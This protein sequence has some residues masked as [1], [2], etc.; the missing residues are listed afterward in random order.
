MRI[1]VLLSFGALGVLALVALGSGLVHWAATNGFG[2]GSARRLSTTDCRARKLI[3]TDHCVGFDDSWIECK[4]YF[5]ARGVPDRGWCQALAAIS[6]APA[7]ALPQC[8][9]AAAGAWAPVS[10]AE[11]R[12]DS[13]LRCFGCREGG[14]E[15]NR[16][17]VYAYDAACAVGIEQV[18]CNF[19]PQRVG[20]AIAELR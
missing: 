4:Y 9:F 11:Y 8:D 15:N 16:T 14:N 12:F 19:D 5:R 3:R 20:R 10:C 7:S 13:A 17:Y 6:R 1:Q 2:L 18:T